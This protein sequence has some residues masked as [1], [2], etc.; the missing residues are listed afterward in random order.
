MHY[1]RVGRLSGLRSGG[2]LHADVVRG[3]AEGNQHPGQRNFCG[4]R[5][6]DPLLPHRTDERLPGGNQ[7][8]QSHQTEPEGSEL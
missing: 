5:P 8:L 6:D 4:L 2:G 1:D 7:R 3:Q